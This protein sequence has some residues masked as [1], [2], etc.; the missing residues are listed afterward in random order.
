[1]AGELSAEYEENLLNTK[2]NSMVEL[3]VQGYFGFSLL[4]GI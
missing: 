4:G 3:V 1:M 2:E